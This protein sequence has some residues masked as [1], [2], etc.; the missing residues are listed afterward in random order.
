[1]VSSRGNYSTKKQQKRTIADLA[2]AA[3]FV[4][5]VG[6]GLVATA[7]GLVIVAPVHPVKNVKKL[8]AQWQE[9]NIIEAVRQ[10]SMSNIDSKSPDELE[11]M[12]DTIQTLATEGDDKT[13][14]MAKKQL[15][16][17]MNNLVVKKMIPGRLRAQK[18]DQARLVASVKQLENCHMDEKALRDM[19]V[20][21]KVAAAEEHKDDYKDSMA[22]RG[23][24]LS[25]L[26][27]KALVRDAYCASVS[28]AKDVCANDQ[29]K[30]LS[31]NK[32]CCDA[33][34]AYDKHHTGCNTD[35]ANSQFASKQHSIIMKKVCAN[36]YT[37][38]DTKKKDHVFVEKSVKAAF[39]HRS[40]AALYRIKCLVVE[41]KKGDGSV[42]AAASKN[43]KNTKKDIQEIDYPKVPEKEDCAHKVDA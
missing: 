15:I 3:K 34:A 7:S 39:D 6:A 25:V 21:A 11:A 43:C 35:K 16:E 10:M 18:A 28:D 36:Y 24:C 42:S 40:W 12:V 33:R 38:Y 14:K 19:N 41:F 2:M 9:G 32:K 27:G 20:G 23:E 17:F 5:A 26:E 31:V 1:L 29:V 8:R 37:C 13:T 30:S 4:A 22:E